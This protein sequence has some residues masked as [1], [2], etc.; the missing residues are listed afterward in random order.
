[1]GLDKLSGTFYVRYYLG[2]LG[3][4]VIKDTPSELSKK[5]YPNYGPIYRVVWK[6]GK[7]IAKDWYSS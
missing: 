3:G 1:M 2:G 5:D 7:R 6:D 4:S